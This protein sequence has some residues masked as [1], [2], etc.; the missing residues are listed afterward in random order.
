LKQNLRTPLA[1]RLPLLDPDKVL[2]K[3]FPVVAPFLSWAG[4]LLW[5]LAVGGALVLAVT[6]WPE[7][8]ENIT[9]RVLAPSNLLLLG[10]TFPFI[11][12]MHEF[13]HALAVRR[14]GGEVHEMGVMFLVF[15]PVPYVDASAATAFR[16]KYKRAL[17]GAAGMLTELLLAALAMFVWANAEP[18]VVRAVAY[19]VI[20]IASVSTLLF[21]GNPLLRFDAYYI[22]ADL[23][24]IP[25]LYSRSLKYLGYLI[26]RYLFGV[27]DIENPVSAPGERAWFVF[28]A[29]AAFIYRLFVYAVIILFVAGK[30]FFVGV[31]LAIWAAVS[32]IMLPLGK[33]VRYVLFSPRLRRKRRRA[34]HTT[35]TALALI[36]A[37]VFLVPVP[38][39]TR[40]E[41]VVWIP[42]ESLVRTGTEGFVEEV[43]VDSGS[44]VTPGTPLIRCGDSLLQTQ[45]RVLQHELAELEARYASE[46]VNDL[47]NAEITRE[48]IKNAS[49][50]LERARERSEQLTIRSPTKGTLVIP[51]WQDMPG[52][53]LKQGDLIG[54]VIDPES[55]TVRAVVSQEQ[56]DLVRQRTEAVDVRLADNLLVSLPGVVEREVPAATTELPSAALGPEGGGGIAVDPRDAEGRRSFQ[57]LFQFEISVPAE[58]DTI[59]VGGR[60]YVRFKHGYEPIAAQGYRALRRLFLKR[61][62]V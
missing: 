41:G 31:L 2:D 58:Q 5:I 42:E 40:A 14:W 54:Y 1:F 35:A 20:L 39:R 59:N 61:F 56:I 57:T 28:Y 16:Q 37:L 27:K 25:N 33:A 13:G 32:M 17:V 36:L 48:E 3:I 53:F 38:L 47:V 46:R 24:E 55:V 49:G 21:N 34:L 45:V 50:R 26:Q 10:V 7:L 52:R 18:G 4:A 6:H 60:A 30:F 19:N 9:D 51:R 22:L 15:M 12:A 23:I 8:T 44:E 11:K 62:D 43:L 29:V